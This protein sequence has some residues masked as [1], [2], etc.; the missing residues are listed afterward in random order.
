LLHACNFAYDLKH[1]IATLLKKRL[2]ENDKWADF[3]KM[4]KLISNKLQQTSLAKYKPPKQRAKARYMNINE[5]IRW[6]K[7]TLN[8]KANI[9]SQE[10]KTDDEKRLLEVL[11]D[12]NNFTKEINGN[13]SL[14][15]QKNNSNSKM[16]L[17]VTR[18]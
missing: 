15:T 5:Q 10:S 9:E 14:S 1:K 3:T 8:I 18:K 16:I 7:K 17:F 12:M 6:A 2:D 4:V 13:F 11:S